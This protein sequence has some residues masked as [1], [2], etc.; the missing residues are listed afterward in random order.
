[1]MTVNIEKGVSIQIPECLM[2]VRE[3]VMYRGG[4]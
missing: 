4:Y 2:L 1:V 3:T